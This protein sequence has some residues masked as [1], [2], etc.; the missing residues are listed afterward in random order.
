MKHDYQNPILKNYSLSFE[1]TQ[2]KPRDTWNWYQNDKFPKRE[3]CCTVFIS[4]TLF[5]FAIKKMHSEKNFFALFFSHT[6]NILYTLQAS[7]SFLLFFIS[8]QLCNWLLKA[9]LE[10]VRSR[11]L[12]DWLRL[13]VTV[14]S[15]WGLK[16]QPI[17]ESSSCPAL[18]EN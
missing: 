15:R 13:R 4:F 5:L 3:Q 17:R 10:W 1:T 14:E 2:N 12:S 18:W 9:I 16:C 7:F 8:F 6:K 11:R